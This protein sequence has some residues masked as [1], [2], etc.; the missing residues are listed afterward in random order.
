M[1]LSKIF[2]KVTSIPFSSFNLIL[3]DLGSKL[4]SF[5][6]ALRTFRTII[7]IICVTFSTFRIASFILVGGQDKR[8]LFIEI[9]TIIGVVLFAFMAEDMIKFLARVVG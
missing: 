3:C 1:D 2:I 4:E 5:Q 9:V 7:L 6:N 8:A